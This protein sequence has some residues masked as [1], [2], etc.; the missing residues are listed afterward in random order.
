MRLDMGWTADDFAHLAK[1]PD[2]WYGETVGVE[3]HG[4]KAVT[5]KA[6]LFILDEDEEKWIPRSVIVECDSEGVI[7]QQWWA[8][9]NGLE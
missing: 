2:D 3:H 6:A 4:V 9:K 1:S 5:D 8:R 7:V